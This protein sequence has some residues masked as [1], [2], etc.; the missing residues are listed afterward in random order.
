MKEYILM[1]NM[2][3]STISGTYMHYKGNRYEIVAVGKHTESGETLVVYR[4][5][6]GDGS[7]WIRPADMF[8]E[9]VQVA[10]VEVPRFSKVNE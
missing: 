7:I 8:L 6:Y 2:N 10:G 9:T 3:Y 5:L 4:A 1:V